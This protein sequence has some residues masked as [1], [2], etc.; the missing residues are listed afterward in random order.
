[1]KSSITNKDFQKILAQSKSL[2]SRDL[3]FYYY[4]KNTAISF[5]VSAKKGNAVLRNLFK[6]R[7][8]ALFNEYKYKELK[9]MQIIIKP[10]YTLQ[11]RYAW[12]DLKLSFAKFC[13]KLSQ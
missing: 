10:I 11:G 12:A 6:R 8:R 7:C 13:S 9:N 3:L 2:L 5:I 4:K 1:M